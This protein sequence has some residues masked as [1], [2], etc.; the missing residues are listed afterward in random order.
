MRSTAQDCDRNAAVRTPA[1]LATRCAHG[2]CGSYTTTAGALP[3][4][5]SASMTRASVSDPTASS[6]RQYSTGSEHDA[7]PPSSNPSEM[8]ATGKGA[9]AAGE[10]D[11]TYRVVTSVGARPW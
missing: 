11:S 2:M 8:A 10:V 7:M 4:R 3:A 6:R 5:A 1:A 9:P